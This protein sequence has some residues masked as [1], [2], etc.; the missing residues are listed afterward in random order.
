M[1]SRLSVFNSVGD[2][3]QLGQSVINGFYQVDANMLP[4]Q[5][6]ESL[7]TLTQRLGE[8]MGEQFARLRTAEDS[9]AIEAEK[10]LLADMHRLYCDKIPGYLEAAEKYH[11]NVN[12][13]AFAGYF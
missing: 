8:G 10:E 6:R 1:R 13:D 4:T 7:D 2:L 12:D 3:S 11:I 9:P 5:L